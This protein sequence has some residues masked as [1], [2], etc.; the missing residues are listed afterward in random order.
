MGNDF[1]TSRNSSVKFTPEWVLV[2]GDPGITADSEP[3][4]TG[5]Y[6]DG[7]EGHAHGNDT[8]ERL[9]A[10]DFRLQEEG[11]RLQDSPPR[12]VLVPP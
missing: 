3:H 7:G 10:S 9:Q 1:R 4:Y 11:V 8:G 5:R 2:L 12:F 6:L